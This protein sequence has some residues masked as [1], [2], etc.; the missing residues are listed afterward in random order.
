MTIPKAAAATFLWF[1]ALTLYSSYIGY[2][3]QTIA[4]WSSFYNFSSA[5]RLLPVV[6]NQ[7][8]E[9]FRPTF[10]AAPYN[11]LPEFH[12]KIRWMVLD[13]LKLGMKEVWSVGKTRRDGYV[14]FKFPFV[15][16]TQ[17]ENGNII[18][19]YTLNGQTKDDLSDE[20]TDDG[21]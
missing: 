4:I 10:E 1:M 8:F 5:R 12:G 11:M 6:I 2:V 21:Y 15:R 20:D 17:H 14:E 18:S 16:P 19:F 3:L 13:A 9:L 7:C